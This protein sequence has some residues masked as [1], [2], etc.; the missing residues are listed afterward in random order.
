[1]NCP[2]LSELPPPPADKAGW[3]WNADDPI[4]SRTRTQQHARISIITPSFNSGAYL[5]ETIRSV[6]LQG[7][8][9]LEYIIIDG[10]ST[11]GSLEIIAKYEKWLRY[12]VSER[13][14]GYADA[15]N[16]GFARATGEI[17]AWL[18][19]S[20]LYTPTA[21]H[22]ANFYLGSRQADL[23]FGR[24]NYL[25]EDGRVSTVQ[26]HV[27]RNLLHIS[28]YGRGNPGQPA[29]FWSSKIHE[30][31][32][33]LNSNLRY[34][35]DS[36]W[37][38]RLSLIGRSLGITEDVCYMREHTG[39]LST[40]HLDEMVSEWHSAWDSVVRTNR[41]SRIRIALGAIL[42][43]PMMRYR[44]GGWNAVF[45]IPNMRTLTASIFG[46]NGQH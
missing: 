23:I 46:H 31:A 28:L 44:S 32:G 15:V 38:L 20:D 1:M 11:D 29:T 39:Q 5:E 17:R 30:K 45:R 27:S 43:V 25:S 12:W 24:T 21:L 16:K 36:E 9:D 18:P 26:P 41:I 42:F 37:F 33:Q 2:L 10:G 34:A 35:A 4:Y 14:Q 13:D 7:Y 3:P 6:L 8:P 40:D 19:A 22:I